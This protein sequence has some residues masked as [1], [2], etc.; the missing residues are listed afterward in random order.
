MFYYQ[1]WSRMTCRIFW[2]NMVLR[3]IYM[4]EISLVINN[5]VHVLKR[6]VL[7]SWILKNLKLQNYMNKIMKKNFKIIWVCEWKFQQNWSRNDLRIISWTT[8]VLY[9]MHREKIEGDEQ[10]STCF[11]FFWLCFQHTILCSVIITVRF[12][13]SVY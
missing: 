7:K 4:E 1:Y 13:S 10:L 2:L 6:I 3:E 9:E 8:V 11:I 5:Y 12:I